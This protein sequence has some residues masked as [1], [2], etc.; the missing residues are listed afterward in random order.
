MRGI[1]F[2]RRLLAPLMPAALLSRPVV[3]ASTDDAR[4]LAAA[5]NTLG[6]QA[7]A[8]LAAGPAP[9]R[10]LSPLS[11][12]DACA[13]LVPA[14]IGPVQETLR[15]AFAVPA[16]ADAMAGFRALDAALPPGESLRRATALWLR[17]GAALLPAYAAAIRPLATLSHH[18]VTFTAPDA[19][20]RINAWVAEATAGRIRDILSPPLD[21]LTNAVITSALH[22][23]ANWA[24]RFDA[25]AT[26]PA[27]FRRARAAPV[28]FPFLNATLPAAYARDGALHAVLL[29]YADEAFEFL[30]VAPAP[31]APVEAVIAA[32]R[33]GRLGAALAAFRFAQADVVVAL[34]RCQGE[35]TT[36]L[37][38][39]LRPT[40][41][42]PA[43]RPEAE[44]GGMLGIATTISQAVQK[45]FLLLD[46]AGTEAAAATAI[47]ALSRGAR[48]QPPE[49]P[50]FRA[51]APFLAAVRHKASGVFVVMGLIAE[52]QPI[53]G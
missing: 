24:R 46:E 17:P 44:Y 7:L 21:P 33:G 39:A 22:F 18:E 50:V 42:G 13:L 30:A 16:G 52:P 47:V 6:L 10:I 37:M 5:A 36:D 4:A 20:P 43:F 1:E 53:R 15:A 27:P 11:L 35:A 31:G 41:L 48:L 3:A 38:A 49:R 23:K 29:P 12:A 34:P 51:D 19:V 25:A 32:L 26:R 2:G 40:P 9:S 8:G 45:A 14:A 28:P